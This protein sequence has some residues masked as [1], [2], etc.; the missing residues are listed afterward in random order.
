MLS[1]CSAHLSRTFS[2]SVI[3]VDPISTES[4]EALEVVRPLDFFQAIIEVLHIIRII[5]V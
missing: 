4:G 3:D 1:K 5:D 2:L